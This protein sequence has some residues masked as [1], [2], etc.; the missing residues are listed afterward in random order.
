MSE[1]VW[2]KVALKNQGLKLKDVAETLGITSPRITD[3]IK[4]KREVQA[5]ELLPLAELLGL[6]V[7][8]LL[9]S[10]RESKRVVLPAEDD[11]RNLP[12]LGK[13]LG[14]GTVLPMAPNDPIKHVAIPPESQSADGL[15]CYIM[16]DNSM[17]GEIKAGDILI[18]ADPRIHFYPMV[19]GSLFLISVGTGSKPNEKIAARQFLQTDTGENWLVPLPPQPNPAFESWRFD[20]LPAEL[21]SL[22]PSQNMS[23]D[24][25]S[26]N[27]RSGKKGEKGTQIADH[28]IVHT[29]DIFAAVLWVHRRYT[30]AS[31][32]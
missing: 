21:T 32:D 29:A 8:S 19:P 24:A 23:R 20:M 31:N 13:L 9:V 2:I 5:D 30:P 11:T 27:I 12:I 14:D 16:G 22:Q 3:I 28:K 10:L 4:G 17:A 26:S 6:S 18:A 15:Y 25:R 7:K 1:Q